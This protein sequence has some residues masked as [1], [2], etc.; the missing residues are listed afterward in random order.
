MAADLLGAVPLQND[1]PALGFKGINNVF[2][3]GICAASGQPF[4]SVKAGYRLATSHLILI[5]F[6]AKCYGET[7]AN[8]NH[9]I[10]NLG[11]YAQDEYF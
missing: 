5:W 2:W 10:A 3:C 1:P 7:I 8:R 6:R 11:R 4:D 9:Y